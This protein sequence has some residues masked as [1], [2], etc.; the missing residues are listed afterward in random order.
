MVTGTHK[1]WRIGDGVQI[2]P[3]ATVNV[4]HLEVEDRTVIGAY[5]VVEGRD[6]RLGREAWIKEYT[7]IGGGS[8]FSKHSFLQVGDFFHMGRFSIINTAR[9]VTIGDEVGLGSHTCIFT[10]GA[11]LSEIDGFP[12][13]FAPVTVG[14]RV[15]L[16]QATVLPGV[17]IGSDVVVAAG[18]LV[19]SNLPSGVLAGGIPARIIHEH[20][21]PQRMNALRTADY[22]KQLIEDDLEL[23]VY[24]I[25]GFRC[26][27]QDT[28]FDLRQ[29]SIKGKVTE[30]SEQLRN[31]FRRHGIRF[32]CTPK[33]GQ[34][35]NWNHA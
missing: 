26:H 11:Y 13:Q 1:D 14:S 31:E 20:A 5:A 12:V 4:E 21:Y 27:M 8:C 17:T 30:E 29:K 19:R 15:W 23:S 33:D 2:H 24:S 25:R 9:A 28:V 22:L 34:Y 10:H 32:K 7:Q 6:V 16:P 35:Q 18:S 3:T